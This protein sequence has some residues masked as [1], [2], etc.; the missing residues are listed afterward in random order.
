MFLDQEPTESDSQPTPS[1]QFVG[2]SVASPEIAEKQFSRRDKQS[3]DYENFFLEREKAQSQKFGVLN[4]VEN[5]FRNAM[6]NYEK[7][8]KDTQEFLYKGDREEELIEDTDSIRRANALRRQPSIRW[9]SLKRIK[10]KAQPS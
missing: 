8:Y 3:K 2:T 5:S 4:V 6:S 1:E 7:S 9:E 10:A